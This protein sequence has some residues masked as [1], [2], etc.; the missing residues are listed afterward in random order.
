[1]E[2]KKILIRKCKEH[3]AANAQESPPKAKEQ[4]KHR[5]ERI[6]FKSNQSN[7]RISLKHRLISINIKY[8]K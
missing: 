1:M 3:K 7:K 4:V 2:S 6:S 8:R 5:K